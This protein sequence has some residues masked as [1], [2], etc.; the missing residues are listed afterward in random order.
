MIAVPLVGLTL[1]MLSGWFSGW[2]SLVSTAIVTAVFFDVEA[3]SLFATGGRLVTLM[4]MT[5][6]SGAGRVGKGCTPRGAPDH[7]KKRGNTTVVPRRIEKQLVGRK[8]VIR[9]GQLS[10][11]LS[12]G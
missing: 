10:G 3:L 8:L 9:R 5:A 7:L 12:V 6:R 4:V 11:A 2:M 1:I